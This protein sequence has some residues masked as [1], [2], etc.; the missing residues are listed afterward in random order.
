LV[1]IQVVRKDDAKSFMEGD[2]FCRQYYKTDKLLFGTSK[3]APGKKG[4]VDP[5]HKIGYEIFYAA[6]GRVI[7]SF[8]KANR[9]VELSEGDIVIIPPGEPHELTN[10]GTE[11]ALV[12]WSLAPPD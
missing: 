11:E 2:E 8:S 6:K 3:L 5:G 1:D 12:V 10:N 7:C 9:Q 4:G